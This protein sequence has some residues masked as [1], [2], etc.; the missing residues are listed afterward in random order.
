MATRICYR[1]FTG[2]EMAPTL[3][4][5]YDL[6]RYSTSVSRME[7][8][9]PNLHGDMER[10]PGMRFL[11]DLGSFSVL[12][13]FSF[14][15]DARQNFLLV[16][17]A[18]RLRVATTDGGLV[19]GTDIY[20]PYAENELYDL[21]YAQVG[22]VVYLAHKN[23]P[24]QKIIRSGTAPN[25][26]WTL[27]GVLLNQSLAAPAAPA[28]SF[29]RGNENDTAEL[30]HTLRY[31]IVAVDASGTQSLPSPAGTCLGKHASDWVTG[32]H[33]TIRW[34]AVSGAVEYNIYREE[35]GYYG[36]IGVCN[37]TTSSIVASTLAGVHIGGYFFQKTDTQLRAEL[38]TEYDNDYGTVTSRYI[39]VTSNDT[40]FLDRHNAF[41]NASLQQLVV[42]APA[43]AGIEEG[44]LIATHVPSTLTGNFSVFEAYP[45]FGTGTDVP[46]GISG[47]LSAI[48]RY[49][50]SSTSSFSFDD[51]NFEPDLS[52]TPKENWNPFE[53]GN[54]PCTVAFHQQRMVLGGTALEPQAFYMSR[55]GDFE[56]FRKSRP[57]QDD[58]PVEY[59]LASGSID[60]IQWITGF[61]DLLIGTSGAEYKAT[62]DQ[63]ASI[64]P[65]EINILSQSYWGSA[66]LAPIIIGNSILHC[67]RNG[68][69]VRD[70]FYS[71]ERDGYAG[72]DLSI[73][74]PHLF[75]GH[76]L[77]QWAY[78]QAPGS[79]LWCVRD[80]GTLL[81]LT[82]L[83]EHGISGWS[84]HITKGKVLSVAGIAGE[85]QD[86]MAFVVQRTINGHTHYFLECLAD[87]FSD[88]TALSDAFFVD[89]GLSISREEATPLVT[90]LS[91]LE[92]ER[93]AVL[94][95]GAPVEGLVVT[96]GSITLPYAARNV[97]VGLAYVSALSPLP[98]ET[99]S[100]SGSTLNR[101]R[102][103]GKCVLR[104]H[105]SIGG[106]YGT[107]YGEG[108][109][110]LPATNLSQ[111]VCSGTNA[112]LF[113]LPFLPETYGAACLP[114]SGDIEFFPE[115]GQAP[116]ASLL[117]V[118]NR[119]LPMHIVALICDIEF[120]EK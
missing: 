113:D 41:Y 66:R 38:I 7:N 32:N 120:G 3:S 80:D 95:D 114:Y 28:V 47:N 55:T 26:V 20:T 98:L 9:I 90:G 87:R 15:V 92:G 84:R 49:T 93:V 27:S 18:N 46:Q 14:N 57:L 58:D 24:L 102:A 81:C 64:T 105:R 12:I 60:A 106:K 6:A 67:Q 75:D 36:F 94:A 77:K 10:R 56:N 22:D 62:G 43:H 96:N 107:T 118:Q 97:Q 1:N 35:A 115:G 82:Y 119:P 42:R 71:L 52:D 103:Y 91:H 99:D 44:W 17:S 19:A 111:G 51:Q 76:T 5:R 53:N 68:S 104:L 88:S 37:A 16:L 54:N 30:S 65:S 25:Y 72:N 86:I 50:E 4:A 59:L 74:A 73:M 61:G 21:S 45:G 31:K 117:I 40:S 78:Q 79:N 69:R 39:S 29:L 11:A 70:L 85:H 109:C 108:S 112:P 63:S 100:G 116:D 23:H 33:V 48:P 13:P 101:R 83:K 8:F 89:C 2:G 34:E 110:V